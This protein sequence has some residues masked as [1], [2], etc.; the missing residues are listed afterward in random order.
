MIY[1]IEDEEIQALCYQA[2]LER[3]G[4]EVRVLPD[5][6]GALREIQREAPDVVVL[7]RRLPDIDG[8]EI[9]N[10]IRERYPTLPI[11]ML[12]SAVLELDI[13]TALDAGADDYMVKPPRERELVA[14]INVLRRRT[15][16]GHQGMIMIEIGSYL[17]DTRERAVYLHGKQIALSPKEYEIVELLA[18]N[19]GH[20]VPR[21]TVV[22][23]VWGHVDE[24]SNSRSLDTHIYRIRHK[25]NLTCSNGVMLRVIYTHGYRLD[26]LSRMD[27][28]RQS[29]VELG[30][31]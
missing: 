30:A 19:V 18:R 11:L 15:L 3:A 10:W 13:V 26:D 2:M 16:D 28:Q 20:V 14:R 23:R 1:V 6:A 24:E 27:S 12:T 21:G 31:G 25:L 7:D 22:G 4:W 29:R 17:I 5:G 8:L 9:L